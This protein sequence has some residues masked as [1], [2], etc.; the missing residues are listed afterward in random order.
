MKLSYKLFSFQKPGRFV[1]EASELG[2]KAGDGIKEITIIGRKHEV[3]YV[4]TLITRHADGEVI[5]WVLKPE[6]NS[7]SEAANTEVV[8]FND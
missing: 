8:I 6:F 2:F 5:G 3:R 7:I 4:C 1:A